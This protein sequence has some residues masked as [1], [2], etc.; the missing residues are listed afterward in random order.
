MIE[1]MRNWKW[2]GLLALGIAVAIPVTMTLTGASQPSPPATPSQSES[3]FNSQN[4]D[5]AFDEPVFDEEG[6]M[7]MAF[8]SD[9]FSEDIEGEETG[10]FAFFSQ[11]PMMMNEGNAEQKKLAK[12]NRLLL[13][14]NR[15]ALSKEQLQQLKNITGDLKKE[16]ESHQTAMAQ[17]QKELNNFLLK[18]N[19]SEEDLK[20]ALQELRKGDP[21]A[22]K[23]H[24][25]KLAAAEKQIKQLL[26]WEQGEKLMKTGRGQQH[27]QMMSFSPGMGMMQQHSG[28]RAFFFNQ[29]GNGPGPQMRDHMQGLQ[30]M[31]RQHMQMGTQQGNQPPMMNQPGQPGQHGSQMMQGRKAQGPQVGPFGHF[32][33]MN[34]DIL[35]EV[36]AAKLAALGS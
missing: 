15:L 32:L 29:R 31:M 3:Y 33:M 23:A 19:G 22:M 20:K 5:E 36:L 25:E 30:K 9:D 16:K 13:L 34:I 27:R 21:E 1:K 4:Q 24:H 17:K 2:L 26:N 10:E 7:A 12:Q 8:Q 6:M 14:L 11:E 28:P 35:D 18:F